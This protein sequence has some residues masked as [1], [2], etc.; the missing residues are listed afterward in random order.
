MSK[1][2]RDERVSNFLHAAMAAPFGLISLVAAFHVA[3]LV[4]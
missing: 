1:F 3:R 4:L 2:F